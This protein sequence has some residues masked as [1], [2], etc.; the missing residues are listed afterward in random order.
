MSN[1]NELKDDLNTHTLTYIQHAVEEIK[2]MRYWFAGFE[3]AGGKLPVCETGISGLH[4]AHILLDEYASLIKK[5]G[6][7]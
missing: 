5:Y 6:K 4:K 7:D 1:K 2:R 3:A